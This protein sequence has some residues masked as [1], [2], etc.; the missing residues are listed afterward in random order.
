[1]KRNNYKIGSLVLVGSTLSLGSRFYSSKGF[2]ESAKNPSSIF[3]F[4]VVDIDGNAVKLNQFKG[5][6]CLVVNVASKCGFTETNYR[7]LVEIYGKYKDKG[8][9]I[10]AFPC[11][12]FGKQEP[13]DSCTIKSF[14]EN[15]KVTFPVFEKIDVNGDNTHPLYKY[16]KDSQ[17]SILGREIKWNFTKF[18]CNKEGVP[19]HRYAPNTS[20]KSIENDILNELNK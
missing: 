1:M 16:L 2:A 5:K 19:I 10:L 20:P 12:Q 8:L 18:L 14:A 3:D 7:E 11:N 15:K 9:E 17:H 6:V 4:E 13:G